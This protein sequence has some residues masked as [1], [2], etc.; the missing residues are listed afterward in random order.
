M[1]KLIV[2]IL[3]VGI[4][5]AIALPNALKAAENARL[6]HDGDG[7]ETVLPETAG[8]RADMLEQAGKWLGRTN[9][10]SFIVI[11]NGRI[12]WE[13]Y[14]RGE[15][16][17][18]YAYT[19]SVANLLLS[20]ITGISIDNG[21]LNPDDRLID[22]YPEYFNSEKEAVSSEIG[23]ITLR[24]VL[25]GA[26]GLCD[27]N[28][29]YFHQTDWLRW[30]LEQKPEEDT[31]ETSTAVAPLT[32]YLVSGAITRSTGKQAAELVN[33]YICAEA[34]M[35]SVIWHTG[36]EGYN[37]G[38]GYAYMRPIDV[39]RLGQL[40]LDVGTYHGRQIIPESWARETL[41]NSYGLT[42]T[43]INKYDVYL[44]QGDG[45]VPNLCLVPEQGLVIVLTAY[46]GLFKASLTERHVEIL[47]SEY[48]LDE[49]W[50][51]KV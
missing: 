25:S 40:Y 51:E 36:P 8:M 37:I 45:T 3:I 17:S 50:G 28:E 34:G 6:R 19:Y 1:K 14:Y 31:E 16:L 49:T 23:Q 33:E 46:P 12:V 15:I 30:M 26:S 38:G 10:T 5:F 44:S 39:A 24:S 7:W 4:S 13:Q 18:D 27:P 41:Y 11:K 2:W 42:K 47:L 20:S 29:D 21:A 43:K 35:K 9:V 48:L 22:Y 32:A